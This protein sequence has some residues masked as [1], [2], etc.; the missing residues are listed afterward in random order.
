MSCYCN[1]RQNE[2]DRI[3]NRDDGTV[4]GY[5][6]RC[7]CASLGFRFLQADHSGPMIGGALANPAKVMPRLFRGTVFER[8]PYLL[9]SMAT[10]LLPAA[11]SIG[12][13]LWIPEASPS[14][15]LS[16]IL[17]V[18]TLKR[19][20]TKNDDHGESQPLLAGGRN[21]EEGRSDSLWD[22][23]HLPPLLYSLWCSGR[24]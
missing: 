12:C 21:I 4:L 19:P 11:G 17:T 13:Y 1:G 7:R 9:P 15:L 23:L 5:R 10:A 18:Q 14:H 6:S 16:E 3:S 20:I 24:E 2:F 22:L 8:L